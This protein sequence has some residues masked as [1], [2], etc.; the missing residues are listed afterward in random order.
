[1]S[2][3]DALRESQRL[4]SAGRSRAWLMGYGVVVV[5]DRDPVPFKNFITTAGDQYYAKKGAVGI[6]PANPTAPTAVTGMKLGTGATAA[7]KS[8]AGA[9]LVTYLT[10]SNAVFDATYPTITAISGTDLGWEI[11]YQVTWAAGTATNSA[12]TE[13]VIVNDAASN[14]TSTAANTISRGLFSSTVNKGSDEPLIV[15]WRH[16]FLG[17]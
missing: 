4:A 7:A 3:E 9:A 16:Q 13:C 6:S 12:I 11:T 5:G 10:G 14:A 8:G 1:M 2:I 15:T 17:S